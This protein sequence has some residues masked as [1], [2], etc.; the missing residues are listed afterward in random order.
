MST[1]CP[2][3]DASNDDT[4]VVIDSSCEITFKDSETIKFDVTGECPDGKEVTAHLID[5]E[6]EPECET[7]TQLMPSDTIQVMRNGACLTISI[8]DL[9]KQLDCAGKECLE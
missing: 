2:N 4:D 6:T 5:T 8:A 7:V 1:D 3:E 9:M